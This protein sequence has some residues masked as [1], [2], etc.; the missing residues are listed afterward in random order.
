MLTLLTCEELAAAGAELPDGAAVPAAGVAPPEHAANSGSALA[1]AKPPN[2]RVRNS[3]LVW[4]RIAANRRWVPGACQRMGASPAP[5]WRPAEPQESL[6][7]T[8]VRIHGWIR[9]W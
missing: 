4:G 7:V 5:S 9:H 2:V 3:R 8:T 1:T 6:T